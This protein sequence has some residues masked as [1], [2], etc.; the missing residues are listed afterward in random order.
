LHSFIIIIYQHNNNR[1]RHTIILEDPFPDPPTLSDHI[2]DASPA[3][4]YADDGRLEDDWIPE[5]ETRNP[6]EIER[7]HRDKEARNRAVV[8]EMIGDLPEADAAPPPN[9]LFICKLNQVTT[10]EDL[11]IIFSRFGTITSCDI[12]R[13]WKTGD[14]LCYAFL[15]FATEKSCEDAYFKMNNVLIDD[16]RIKVDFSQSVHHLWKQFKRHGRRGDVGLGKEAEGHE[17]GSGG[18]GHRSLG[19]IASWVLVELCGCG[20][21][22][23]V[24]VATRH[25]R[26]DACASRLD[27]AQ[28]DGARTVVDE[29]VLGAPEFGVVS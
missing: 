13:D 9:M 29:C 19:D 1:I 22:V 8:L 23:C 27:A 20:C 18:G 14:S 11:E 7:T 3:P 26:S 21:V 15:G 6:E 10:E 17:R 25:Y 12:I 24:G 2:P 4:Q 28:A 5:E 16:R